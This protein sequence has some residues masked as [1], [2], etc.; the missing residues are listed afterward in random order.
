MRKANPYTLVSLP[1][2]HDV[3]RQGLYLIGGSLKCVYGGRI[4]SCCFAAFIF[5]PHGWKNDGV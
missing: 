4:A 2:D 5:L 3:T 1:A